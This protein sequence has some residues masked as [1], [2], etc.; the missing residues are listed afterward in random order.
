MSRKRKQ[1]DLRGPHDRK[2]VRGLNVP[3]WRISS[4]TFHLHPD[5]HTNPNVGFA[6]YR[7]RRPWCSRR[8]LCPS[9][10]DPGSLDAPFPDGSRRPHV[11]CLHPEHRQSA[12]G[13]FRR[14]AV[15]ALAVECELMATALIILL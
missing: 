10:V 7:A 8:Y 6:Q 15:R 4:C 3:L 1:K 11:L 13:D 5:S 9:A 2:R 12:G 14:Y